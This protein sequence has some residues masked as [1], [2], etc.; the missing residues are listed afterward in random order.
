[1]DEEAVMKLEERTERI[2]K[3]R[4]DRAKQQESVS[5]NNLIY[6]VN[7]GSFFI[8]VAKDI[9]LA[10]VDDFQKMWDTHS[11]INNLLSMHK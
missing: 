7:C 8:Y 1:M 4:Q 2:R 11:N 5:H 9:S 10:Y 6:I 3:M